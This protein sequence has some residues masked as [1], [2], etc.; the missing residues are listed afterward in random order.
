MAEISDYT[1][2]IQPATS[3]PNLNAADLQVLS[4]DIS[5]SITQVGSALVHKKV[6]E[7]Y[8]QMS[9]QLLTDKNILLQIEESFISRYTLIDELRGLVKYKKKYPQYAKFL[10]TSIAIDVL[11]TD[12][13]FE[14]FVSFLENLNN[15]EFEPTLGEPVPIPPPNTTRPSN[16]QN[17][18]QANQA[19]RSVTE[20]YQTPNKLTLDPRRSGLYVKFGPTQAINDTTL[21]WM[22]QNAYSYGFVFYGPYDKSVWLYR[23]TLVSDQNLFTEQ[24]FL[25]SRL[26]YLA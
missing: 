8:K 17:V 11:Y 22:Y 10:D 7:A 20:I 25:N 23:K 15:N 6:Y 19:V 1:Q 5:N 18:S 14:S 9:L 2:P 12:E 3:I 4:N 16:Q 24:S 26:N 21:R 13:N